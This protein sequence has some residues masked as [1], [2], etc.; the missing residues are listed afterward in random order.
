MSQY[1]EKL[2]ATSMISQMRWAK[3]DACPEIKFIS[4]D[5]VELRWVK[6][7]KVICNRPIFDDNLSNYKNFLSICR[8]AK[9]EMRGK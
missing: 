1:S 5:M 7:G 3:P 6:N 8:E 2:P 9:R 4:E